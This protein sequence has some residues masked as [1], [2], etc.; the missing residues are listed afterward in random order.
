MGWGVVEAAARHHCCEGVGLDRLEAGG[1][2]V[3]C[4]AGQRLLGCEGVSRHVPAEA[5]GSLQAQLVL[6]EAREAVVA[7]T[8]LVALG[9]GIPAD[10]RQVHLRAVLAEAVVVAH[11]VGL[12][13]GRGVAEAGVP[14][15]VADRGE[16]SGVQRGERQ[17]VVA[18]TG[19]LRGL[20]REEVLEAEPGHASAPETGVLLGLVAAGAGQVCFVRDSA[21]FLGHRAEGVRVVGSFEG[22]GGV[23]VEGTGRDELRPV[24]DGRARLRHPRR[25][26]PVAAGR[27]A[28]VE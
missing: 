11:E 16:A 14:G 12:R 4:R 6:D 5:D 21:D 28:E 17:V 20:F 8:G 3:G 1:D 27:R 24:E 23:V 22:F 9:L 7:W 26:G 15:G 25:P 2:F 18:G 10:S 19:L 13:A